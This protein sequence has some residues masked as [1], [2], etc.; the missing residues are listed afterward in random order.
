MNLASTITGNSFSLTC[1]MRCAGTQ[2]YGVALLSG[3]QAIVTGNVFGGG[4]AAVAAIHVASTFDEA[5]IGRRNL[6][7]AW[8]RSRGPESGSRVAMLVSLG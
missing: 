6:H 8:R 2:Q 7:G 5:A 4:S 3:S 1:L